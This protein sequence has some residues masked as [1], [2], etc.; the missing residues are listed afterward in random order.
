MA[1][2]SPKSS[3]TTTT[4]SV[5]ERIF[6][7]STTTTTAVLSTHKTSTTVTQASA[8]TVTTEKPAGLPNELA[9]LVNEAAVS[10]AADG[11]LL[12]SQADYEF[13]RC[14]V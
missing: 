4:K 1:F 6:D 9:G 5:D 14:Q 7:E 2:N 11:C 8:T 13:Q 12:E 10:S 3:T